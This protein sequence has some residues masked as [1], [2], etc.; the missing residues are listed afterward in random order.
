MPAAR[1]LLGTH[2][3]RGKVLLELQLLGLFGIL[4]LTPARQPALHQYVAIQPLLLL[5]PLLLPQHAACTPYLLSSF[6]G[7]FSGALAGRLTCSG[8]GRLA[9]GTASSRPRLRLL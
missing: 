7:C 1:S 4:L 9:A 3:D 5:L 6:T 2:L 8:L